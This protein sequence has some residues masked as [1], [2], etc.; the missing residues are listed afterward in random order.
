MY[1]LKTFQE[2]INKK[3]PDENLQVIEFN[4]VCYPGTIKCLDCGTL[5]TLK[6]ARNFII[7]SK[8]ILCKKCQGTKKI[9]KEVKNKIEYILKKSELKVIR[10]FTLISENMI[11]QCPQCGEEF[12]RKPQIF[13][14]TQKCPYC[15]SRSKLKPLSVFKQDLQSRYGNEYQ[16]LGKYINAQTPTLF[17]HTPCGFKWPVRPNDILQKAPC[18]RCKKYSRGEKEIEFFLKQNNID[19][20]WQK[21]FNDLPGLS[22]DFYLKKYRVLIEFQGEQHYKP[23]KHFGGK[24]KFIY[25]QQNDKKKREYARNNGYTLLEIKY[26]DINDVQKILSDFI[27]QRLN[28]QAD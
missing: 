12:S 8:N 23:I 14:K 4:G 13:L 10:P 2:K 9:T 20:I 24:E 3:Y 11:F 6:S 17:E 7:D 16:I 25:Q 26:T 21:R 18:P 1:T 27:A 15:E 28:V 19:Y 22:Y 5:Y